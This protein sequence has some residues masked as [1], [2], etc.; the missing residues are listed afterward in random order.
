MDQTQL[1]GHTGNDNN[2]AGSQAA[3]ASARDKLMDE[4]HNVIGEAE[5]WLKNAKRQATE[6]DPQIRARFEDTLRTAKSDLLRLE[7]SIVARTRVAAQSANTYVKENPWKTVGLSAAA[8]I[9]IGM[10]IARK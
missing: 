3:S 4:L 2:V 1:N 7:D 9:I 6:P 5:Q 8:G 10:L